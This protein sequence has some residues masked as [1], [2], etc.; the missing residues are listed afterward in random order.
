M[1]EKGG[2]LNDFKLYFESLPSEPKAK[3]AKAQKPQTKPKK[4]ILE[5]NIDNKLVIPLAYYLVFHR[6]RK[7]RNRNTVLSIIDDREN[8][9]YNA[10][11]ATN[12]NPETKTV[13]KYLNS[14]IEEYQA[15]STCLE[16][17]NKYGVNKSTVHRRLKEQG[18]SIRSRSKSKLSERNPMWLGDN[19]QYGGLHIWVKSRKPK[20]DK[21]EKCNNRKAIDLANISHKYNPKTYTRDLS[22]WRWLCR[23]CHMIEDGRLKIFNPKSKALLYD[24][25]EALPILPPTNKKRA[26]KSKR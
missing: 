13:L 20:P 16:I 15:G 4:N 9:W 11:M 10:S 1:K 3:R 18:V 7:T 14:W 2:L 24:N 17:A 26:T 19:V 6:Q 8:M 23:R 22:N 5:N 12:S 25:P 21:C